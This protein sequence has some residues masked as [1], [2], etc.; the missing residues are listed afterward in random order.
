MLNSTTVFVLWV[1][2]RHVGIFYALRDDTMTL[3]I[4]CRTSATLKLQVFILT[5]GNRVLEPSDIARESCT[6]RFLDTARELEGSVTLRNNSNNARSGFHFASRRRAEST[7][8]SRGQK[9]PP[10]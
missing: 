5:K 1:L 4:V 8:H 7:V 2:T 9:F 10:K 3:R 6:I